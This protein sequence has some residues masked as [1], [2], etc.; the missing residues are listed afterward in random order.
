MMMSRLRQP[1]FV[2]LRTLVITVCPPFSLTKSSMLLNGAA[3]NEL[4][5][6]RKAR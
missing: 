5:P 1:E 3:S 6:L 4:P 2:F